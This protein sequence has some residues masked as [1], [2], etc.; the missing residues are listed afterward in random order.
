MVWL[1]SLPHRVR[2]LEV[3]AGAG[4]G[5]GAAKLRRTFVNFFFVDPA[6]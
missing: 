1:N 2:K 5:A 3:A 4:A 6:K